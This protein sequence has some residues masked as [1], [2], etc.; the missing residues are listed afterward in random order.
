[1]TPFVGVECLVG[2]QQIGL[3]LGQQVIGANQIMGLA[4]AQHERDRVA[5]SIDER[6]NFGAQSTAGSPDGMIVTGFF[7]APT[8]C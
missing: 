2:D 3:H 8:L 4:A 1:M 7:L 5:Q 6:V